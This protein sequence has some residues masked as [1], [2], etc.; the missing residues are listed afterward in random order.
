MEPAPQ[1]STFQPL[2]RREEDEFQKR[3]KLAALKQCDPVVAAFASC[4]S[5]RTISVAWACRKEWKAVQECMQIHMTEEKLDLARR[6]YMT[7]REEL[8]V[9]Y[10]KLS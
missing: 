2:S 4:S 1:S 10:K 8:R 5:T 7:K 3:I 9:P 6:E